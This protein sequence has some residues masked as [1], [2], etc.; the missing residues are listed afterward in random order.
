MKTFNNDRVTSSIYSRDDSGAPF[1]DGNMLP[2]SPMRD[3]ADYSRYV[4]DQPDISPPDTPVDIPSTKRYS[5]VSPIDN[6]KLF[7]AEV[8][9]KNSSHLPVPR[10]I[11]PSDNPVIGARKMSLGASSQQTALPINQRSRAVSERSTA[12]NA[13]TTQNLRSES[14]QLRNTD[15]RTKE[16]SGLLSAG[17]ERLQMFSRTRD[18]KQREPKQSREQWKGASGRT[19]LVPPI[20]TKSSAKHGKKLQANTQRFPE[21]PQNDF[22]NSGGSGGYTVTTITAGNPPANDKLRSKTS[23]FRL[24]PRTASPGVKDSETGTVTRRNANA[25]TDSLTPESA[26]QQ[27]T[28]QF[29]GGSGEST[30][31]LEEPKEQLPSLFDELNIAQE[32]SSRFSVSTY[33]PTEAAITPPGSSHADAPPMPSF[34]H[35][36]IMTRRRPI[37]NSAA[38]IK[39]M[40]RK[41][42]SSSGTATLSEVDIKSL[43]PEEQTQRRIDSLE[44]RRQQLS[45]RKE[46]IKTMLH[47]LTEVIQPSSVAYDMATRDEVKKTVSSLKNE[48]DDIGKE[49]HEIGLKLVRL[50]KNLNSVSDFEQ[51]S[52]WVKRITS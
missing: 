21:N 31:I 19:P 15:S 35:S 50:Y 38:S 16:S 49:D 37:Q 23:Q 47:E 13:I 5:D 30:P 6:D 51:S 18:Q 9:N 45:L 34:D 22:L 10:R 46:S 1:T 33:A 25:S 41:P 36:P 7:F 40:K 28:M 24:R 3:Y 39:S 32:P 48:L 4:E 20:D 42:V 29:S 12:S 17:K 8:P 43:T 27:G 2:T 11:N 52:L 26:T 14:S 44:S